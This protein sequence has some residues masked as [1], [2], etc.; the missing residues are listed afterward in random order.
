M[1]FSID[2]EE[3]AGNLI[4]LIRTVIVVGDMHI[5]FSW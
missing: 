1:N 5:L 4:S 3:F 2:K